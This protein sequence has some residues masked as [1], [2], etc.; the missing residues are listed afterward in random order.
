MLILCL[1]R[2]RNRKGGNEGTD[3]KLRLEYSRFTAQKHFKELLK[4][5]LPKRRNI[6]ALF[7][8]NSRKCRERTRKQSNKSVKADI[9]NTYELLSSPE[10]QAHSRV[11][12]TSKYWHI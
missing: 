8:K 2:S 12:P 10:T 1:H 11:S 4:F 5:S 9:N 6:S 7:Y 3:I